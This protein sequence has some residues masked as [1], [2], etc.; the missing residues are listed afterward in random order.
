MGAARNDW[1]V[2]EIFENT[3]AFIKEYRAEFAD[4][5]GISIED[6]NQL[7]QYAMLVRLIRRKISRTWVNTNTQYSLKDGNKQVYYFSMEFLIG[8]LLDNYLV[9]LGLRDIVEEGLASLGVDL[10]E[11]EN[12][13]EDAGLGNGGLGRLAACFLDSMAFLGIAGHG[14]GIR[15]K[16]GLFRQKIVD[17]QQVE[18]PDNWLQHGYPWE[19]RKPDKSIVVKF[20]GYVAIK[21]EGDKTRFVHENYDAVL[22]VPYDVPIIGYDRHDQ[23]NTLRLW[24]AEQAGDEFDFASFNRGDYAKAVHSRSEAEAISYILYPNDNNQSGQELRLKQEYFLVAA[25]VGGII[26]R[27]KKNRN[28]LLELNDNISI[29]INDTHPAL[30]VAELMRILVDDESINWERAWTITVNTISFTNHTVMPEALER[31]PEEMF[32]RLLPRIHQIICEIDRR[33][34]LLLERHS[35]T[36]ENIQNTSIIKDGQLH[37]VNLAVIGSHSINGVAALHTEILKHDI[38]KDF[39][40]N[41]PYK[42]K[43][44]TNGVSH[45]RFLLCANPGLSALITEAI[46]DE[47]IKDFRQVEKLLAFE[48]DAAFLEKFDRVKRENKI[49]LANY[50]RETS[51]ISL[52]PDSLFDV[53]VKRIHGYKRQL[54]NVLNT[55]HL[56]NHIK[57]NPKADVTPSTFIIAGK[58][59]PGYHFAKM[60]IHLITSLADK[61]NRDP[62]ASKFIKLVFVDNFNISIGELIYPA[63]NISQQISTAG[64]E[65]SGTGNMKQMMNGAITLGTFDGAN[66]EI[67]EAV[68]EQNIAIFGLRV[69]QVMSFYTKGGYYSWDDYHNDFRLKRVLDQLINGFFFNV[70]NEFRDIYDGL[71][72]DNDEYFV[73]KD[74]DSYVD[75][76]AKLCGWYSDKNKWN[77]VSLRN[78]A[79]SWSFSSD[80]TIKRYEMDIW[81]KV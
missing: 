38:L 12:I 56:Y 36:Y 19:I 66:V 60:I 57:D 81:N 14:N 45:R 22:A 72:R 24:S 49:R 5:L 40:V 74:F 70:G 67:M 46:G 42:F 75:A 33:H 65:A 53:H 17:G 4:H 77:Q 69:D 11:L 18:L 63:S 55:M 73:L 61:I 44:E 50:V 25:G 76:R 34:R 20:N 51:S 41:F 9:N 78:I 54:M 71:L 47:W 35:A 7:E 28:N 31:W 26:Q 16:F 8:K 21:Q 13:E 10:I 15:Y 79:H 62:V 1:G 80:E 59:A 6:S 37:M 2:A 29:H 23:I 52:D 48:H 3:S 58:A 39:Y 43:N 27:Y 32:R 68:G 30:C 64:K